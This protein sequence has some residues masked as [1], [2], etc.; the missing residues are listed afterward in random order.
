MKSNFSDKLGVS[1]LDNL[2]I[3]NRKT[4]HTNKLYKKLKYISAAYYLKCQFQNVII[5]IGCCIFF[6]KGG[7]ERERERGEGWG[8]GIA[9]MANITKCPT[10]PTNLVTDKIYLKR[11]FKK[12]MQVVTSN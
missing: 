10:K 4:I 11:K 8:G 7:A 2:Y 9:Y 5:H 6:W 1:F 3:H 12:F